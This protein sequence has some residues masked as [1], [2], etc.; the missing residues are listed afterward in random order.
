[1]KRSGVR[2]IVMD[3]AARCK[4]SWAT[5]DKGLAKKINSVESFVLRLDE[6]DLQFVKSDSFERGTLAP[7]TPPPRA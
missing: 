7:P 1:M 5:W 2:W 3:D 6:V 4:G